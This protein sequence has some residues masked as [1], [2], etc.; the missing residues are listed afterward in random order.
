MCYLIQMYFKYGQHTLQ[1]LD[2]PMV[3]EFSDTLDLN[4]GPRE[5]E[6]EKKE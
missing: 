6:A 2:F 5:Y 1:G 3:C 4:L